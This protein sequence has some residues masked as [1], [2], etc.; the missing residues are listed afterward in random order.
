M[1]PWISKAI[2][3]SAAFT[4]LFCIGLQLPCLAQSGPTNLWTLRLPDGNSAPSPAIAPDGTT[5]Q[6][7]FNGKLLADIPDA[8]LKWTFQIRSDIYFSLAIAS[9]GTIYV[10]N[11]V[12]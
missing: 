3:Q 2:C 7:I 12:F 11:A 8:E 10:P 1:L 4:A 9:D 5:Y 6:A